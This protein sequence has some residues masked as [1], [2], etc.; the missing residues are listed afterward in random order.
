MIAWVLATNVVHDDDPV[1]L[2]LSAFPSEL[3]RVKARFKRRIP[4]A[5]V[6]RVTHS[7]AALEQRLNQKR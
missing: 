5:E 1:E 6:Q 4:S 7:E 3:T 2:V